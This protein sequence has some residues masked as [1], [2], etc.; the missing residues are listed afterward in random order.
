VLGVLL[1]AQ[2]CAQPQPKVSPEQTCRDNLQVLLRATEKYAK[3]HQNRY[4]N[5]LQELVPQYLVQLPRCPLELDS[6][7]RYSVLAHDPERVFLICS[8]R[9]HQLSPPDYLALSSD[10]GQERPFGSPADPS[11]CRRVLVQLGQDLASKK[12]PQRGY[13]ATI[14]PNV[15]CSC[16]DSLRYKLRGGGMDF[17]AFCPGGAHLGSGLAPFSPYL[18]SQGLHEENLVLASPQS[19]R[20]ASSGLGLGYKLAGG[21][22]LLTLLGMGASVLRRQRIRLD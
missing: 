18:D 6:Y 15:R 2:V 5:R 22:A 10:R 4:P 11:I 7:I 21:L 17:V 3:D 13:P 12:H 1:G 8:S 19:S 20:P 9:Q 14:N 16:G